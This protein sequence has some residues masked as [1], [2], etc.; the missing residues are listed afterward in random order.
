MVEA[1]FSKK[2]RKVVRYRRRKASQV[3]M[4][5]SEFVP[6]VATASS[7]SRAENL[8]V[9]HLRQRARQL[10]LDSA[11]SNPMWA[12][13]HFVYP[14]SEYF[15]AKGTVSKRLADLSNLIQGPE[16]ALQKAGIIESDRLIERLDGSMRLWHDEPHH[17]LR[18]FLS[19]L[20]LLFKKEEGQE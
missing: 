15:T 10:H 14:K 6:F 11:I 9:L 13:F 18:I 7:E 19:P 8:L 2:N 16:D 12:V 17:E 20:D 3:R 1:F 5:Q 4:G